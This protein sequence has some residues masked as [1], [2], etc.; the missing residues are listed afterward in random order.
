M[1]TKKK[2]EIICCAEFKDV[3]RRYTCYTK[4][5]LSLSLSL[6]SKDNNEKLITNNIMPSPLP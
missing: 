1:I 5:P 2:G 3:N 4:R 6:N